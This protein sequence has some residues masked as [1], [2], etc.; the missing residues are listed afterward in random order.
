ME[1]LA[2]DG[3]LAIY[4]HDGYWQCMDTYREL[5]MLNQQWTTGHAPWTRWWGDEGHAT[6]RLKRSA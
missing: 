4:K 5:Q 3:Q 6:T 2:A 1:R